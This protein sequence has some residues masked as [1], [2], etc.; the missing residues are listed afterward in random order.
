MKVNLETKNLFF[1][2]INKAD[3]CLLKFIRLKREKANTA[4]IRDEIGTIITDQDDS[5]RI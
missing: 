2:K 1:V 3:K 4:K 5:K